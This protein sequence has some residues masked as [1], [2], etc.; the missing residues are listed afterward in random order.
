MYLRWVPS[1]DPLLEPLDRIARASIGLTATALVSSG[2]ADLTLAQ[3][4]LI[5]VVA[6]TP[7]PIH[8]GDIASRLGTSMPSASRL[9]R[10][11]EDRRLVATERDEADRRS[12]LVRLTIAGSDLWAE[13]VADRRAAMARLLDAD[14]RRPRDL[15]GDLPAGLAAIADAFEELA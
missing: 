4:R 12:T 9:V 6:G 3:W 10:R 1:S 15:P 11:L 14:P 2:H 8:V 5:A 7:R 13:V